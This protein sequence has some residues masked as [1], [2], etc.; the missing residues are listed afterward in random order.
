MTIFKIR[1]TPT[2]HVRNADGTPTEHQRNA[3][4]TLTERNN[5]DNNDNNDNKINTYVVQINEVF[6]YLNS[7]TGKNYTGRSKA[8]REHIVARL[9]EGYT[10]EEFKRVIDNKV[11]AWGDDPKMKQYLR[12]ETLFGTKFETYLNDTEDKKQKARREENELHEKQRDAIREAANFNVG[13]LEW[14]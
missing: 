5:N 4:G 11:N 10:V 12:P 13:F 7:R 3:D 2:E 9:K 1:R 8:Q 14:V 6:D